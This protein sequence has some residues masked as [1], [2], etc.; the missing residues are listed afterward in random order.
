MRLTVLYIRPKILNLVFYFQNVIY[1]VVLVSSRPRVKLPRFK[2]DTLQWTKVLNIVVNGLNLSSLAAGGIYRAR[3][4]SILINHCGGKNFPFCVVQFYIAIFRKVIPTL[5]MGFLHTWKF[6]ISTKK[7]KYNILKLYIY[8][9][10]YIYI[11]LW[12]GGH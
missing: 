4:L 2:N 9:Y 10:I 11:Y 12:V 3:I 7:C 5:N 6:R 1:F 8:I